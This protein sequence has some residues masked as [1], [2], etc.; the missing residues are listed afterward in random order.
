[1]GVDAVGVDDRELGEGL[2]PVRDDLA[3]DEPSGGFALGGGASFLLGALSGSFV[4]DVADRQPEQLGHGLVVGEVAAVLD[5]RAQLVVQRLQPASGRTT[6]PSR[7]DTIT[8]KFE[9]PL[10][11]PQTCQLLSHFPKPEPVDDIRTLV[12][13]SATNTWNPSVV[14]SPTA[15]SGST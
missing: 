6:G 10:R 1:M 12:G 5:A 11:D 4:L 2:L 13:A 7:H 15:W 14:L 9:E 3:F 8:R